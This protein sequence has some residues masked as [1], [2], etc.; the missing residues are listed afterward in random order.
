MSKKN[1]SPEFNETDFYEENYQS[2]PSMQPMYRCPYFS[3]RPMMVEPEPPEFPITSTPSQ[4]P[5]ATDFMQDEP[6]LKNINYT[7]AFLRTQIGKR[8]R[9]E[10]LIGTNMVVDRGGIL[11]EVGI[12]YI[13]IRETATNVKIMCDL[14]S[15]KF[16]NIYESG[17]Q[18]CP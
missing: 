12:S 2:Y 10:F 3:M 14:Y 7:Q 1:H 9:V 17:S 4:A 8:V 16:V 6:A 18:I 5:P 13:V 11:E 15:I